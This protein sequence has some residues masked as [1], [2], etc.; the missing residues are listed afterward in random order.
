ME[1]Y[2]I[3]DQWL[4][5]TKQIDNIGGILRSDAISKNFNPTAEYR[6]L[7][8][9][10]TG[11]YM[12]LVPLFKQYRAVKE[13][14]EVAKYVQLKNEQTVKFVSAAAEREASSFVGKERYLRDFLE[15]WMLAAES[16]IYTCKKH[17]DSDTKE[18]RLA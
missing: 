4:E 12:Y 6:R 14:N 15:G 3:P 16:G 10:L 18:E 13:N 7:L 2:S 17:I 8:N 11:S 9:V 1:E 5:V